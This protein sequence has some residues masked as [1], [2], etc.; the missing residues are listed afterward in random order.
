MLLFLL[1]A[2]RRRD[3]ASS[4]AAASLSALRESLAAARL[5][6]QDQAQDDADN[7]GPS[8]ADVGAARLPRG[9]GELGKLLLEADQPLSEE[10]RELG[11]LWLGHC[12]E[13]SRL[14]LEVTG[15]H[16]GDQSSSPARESDEELS[17]L[18]RATVPLCGN[19]RVV[20]VGL[21]SR[22]ARRLPLSRLRYPRAEP[23]L[24][25]SAQARPGRLQPACRRRHRRA[26][27]LRST[28]RASSTVS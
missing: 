2:S 19:N 16:S 25:R 5:R 1:T 26:E 28:R 6:L 18:V 9:R 12:H 22:R 8:S 21:S 15:S 27:P 10:P 7:Q 17:A 4:I 20:S 11:L 23:C 24:R 14:G 3:T 13:H